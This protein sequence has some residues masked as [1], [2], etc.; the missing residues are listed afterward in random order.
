VKGNELER[1][2]ER[3][4]V[5][6]REGGRDSYLHQKTNFKVIIRLKTRHPFPKK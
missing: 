6:K 3:N 4:G 5:R 1:E 2:R